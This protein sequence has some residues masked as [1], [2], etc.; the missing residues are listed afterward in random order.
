MSDRGGNG[1]G[2]GLGAKSA[3]AVPQDAP[4]R[5]PNHHAGIKRQNLESVPASSSGMPASRRHRACRVLTLFLGRGIAVGL[6]AGRLSMI[7]LA[8]WLGSLGR[9]GWLFIGTFHASLLIGADLYLAGPSVESVRH[10][11]ADGRH[12][13]PENNRHSRCDDDGSREH[14][15]CHGV[16]H[17]AEYALRSTRF[18]ARKSATIKLTRYQNTAPAGLGGWGRKGI[19]ASPVPRN[20]LGSAHYLDSKWQITSYLLFRVS[21]RIF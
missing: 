19:S 1:S 5:A 4:L 18:P 9:L 3:R 11:G 14:G 20:K 15:H 13:I 7:D 17:P 10:R 2:A 6:L 16:V 21:N 8:S 12:L